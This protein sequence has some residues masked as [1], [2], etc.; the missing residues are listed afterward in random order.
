MQD[1]VLRP[2][3]NHV[4]M[5]FEN[6]EALANKVSKISYY[7]PLFGKAF[8]NTYIDSTRIKLAITEFLRN[9]NF[10][11]NKFIRAEKSME[12][13]SASENL[14]KTVFFNKGKC[15]NCHHIEP[16]N[17]FMD[18]TKT[19]YGFTNLEFNIGLDQ[20]YSDNGTGAISRNSGQDGKFMVPVLLNVEYTAP[21]MHDGRFKTLEEV[22]EHYNS[23]IK[24]HPNLDVELRDIDKFE[25][26]SENELMATLDLNKNGVIEPSEIATI[27]PVRLNLTAAEKRGLVDFLKTLSD[28]NIFTDARFRNPFAKK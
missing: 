8:G 14:G 23:G 19:G 11:D 27:P 17:T 20:V 28:P 6:L 1:L 25:E 2:I 21:Y 16:Q 15:S 22:V 5:K 9:F 10:A 4:E 26:M 18:S 7:A 12:R 24:N 3:K 13:L